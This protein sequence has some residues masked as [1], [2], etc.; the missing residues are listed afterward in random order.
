MSLNNNLQCKPLDF[1]DPVLF[2]KHFEMS[3]LNLN[4]E[5]KPWHIIALFMMLICYMVFVYLVILS[6]DKLFHHVIMKTKKIKDTPVL[7][8]IICS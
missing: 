1:K 6:C 2:D 7:D 3:K 5:I 8:R 4:L